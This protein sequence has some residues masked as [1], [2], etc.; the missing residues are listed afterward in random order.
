MRSPRQAGRRTLP[1]DPSHRIE[2]IQDRRSHPARTP[3][4]RPREPTD[5]PSAAAR[6]APGPP[7]ESTPPV[8]AARKR[9]RPAHPPDPPTTIP[10]AEP[11]P[12]FLTVPDVA[13]LLQLSTKTVYTL[14]RAGALP[15]CVR[16]GN[17][18]RFHREQL[19]DGLARQALAGPAAA[20]RRP[21]PGRSARARRSS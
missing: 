15:G 6:H 12:D 4:P 17:A 21:A 10:T 5:R 18:V 14:A 2:R 20:A 13:R 11:L 7:S 8:P 16:L 3:P 1:I 19:L 9:P